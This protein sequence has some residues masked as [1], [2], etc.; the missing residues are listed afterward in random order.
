[1]KIIG[2]GNAL[3][4]VLIQLPDD[5]IINQLNLPKGSMHLI[6]S[7]DIPS[8]T[9]YI[10]IL[11]SVMVSGGSAANTIHGLA[12]L[13]SKCGFIGKV[14][15]DKLGDFYEDDLKNAGVVS[16]LF[17]SKTETGRAYTFITPDRERTFATYLGAAVELL[18]ND[19]TANLFI[20][21]DILH[22]EGYLINNIQLIDTILKIA[23]NNKLKIS[24]DMASYNIVEINLQFLRRIIPKYID[25]L[26]ANEEESK[27]YTG[28]NPFDAL[29][30]IANQCK[31]AVVK[32]G[33]E[34]SLIKSGNETIKVRAIPANVSDTTGAG[35]Q[36]AA[37][38]LYGLSQNFDLNTCGKL[39]SLLAGKVI[40]NYGARIPATQW[41][42]IL[43]IIKEIT[44]LNPKAS[45]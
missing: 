18:A 5:T 36:Y 13:G 42:E 10:E 1:M 3:V 11:P 9:K 33:K 7:T 32:V 44:G 16:T 29:N 8:M 38:F 25:I 43:K 39:G 17:K 24:L 15:R 26:F 4:D 34:G 40:E 30:E 27:A 2:L 31:I 45:F 6:Q 21:Y 37:G 19:L 23:K 35:D 28:K 20:G 12:S 41:Y 14:G 22:I